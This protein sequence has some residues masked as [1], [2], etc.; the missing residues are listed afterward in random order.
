MAVS[1]KQFYQELYEEHLEE[2]AF[3]YDSLP[4]WREDPEGSWAD[5][6]EL[7]QRLETHI[8]ALVIGGSDAKRLLRKIVA[9]A[10]PGE[11]FVI[12]SVLCRHY[13]LADVTKIWE[14]LIGSPKDLKELATEDEEEADAELQDKCRAVALAVR[15]EYP[16]DALAKLTKLLNTPHGPLLPLVAPAV[17]PGYID[18]KA[19]HNLLK[20]TPAWFLADALRV[21]GDSG[22]KTLIPLLEPY[23][24]PQFDAQDLAHDARREAA[25][26]LLKL[27]AFD[28]IPTL[29]S[30]PALFAIPLALTGDNNAVA[31]LMELGSTEDPSDDVLYALGFSGQL[32]AVKP[33]V[34]AMSNEDKASLAAD[35]AQL[36]LA[37]D[38]V[39]EQFIDEQFA[40]EDLFEHE[41]EAFKNGE[42]PKHPSGAAYGEN[43]VKIS[44]DPEKW[45]AWLRVNRE[46]FDT[47]LC[48]RLGEPLSPV[49]ICR[50]L[51][52]PGVPFGIRRYVQD[53]LAIRFKI[54]QAFSVYDPVHV[55]MAN[56]QATADAIKQAQA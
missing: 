11:L 1:L 53:E 47:N 34:L 37:T 15:F 30:E 42:M 51:Y 33:L 41:L 23:I 12:T 48:Y 32:A 46:R 13:A 31:K 38:L 4:T 8:D 54:R 6:A 14:S 3:L 26:A 39:E 44:C 40:E 27:G 29:L 19:A 17:E 49:S 52:K 7:E 16:Q 28:I 22:Q 55:Q 35:A 36:I 21:L 20:L 18:E 9:E 5:C 2:G 50:S 10:E 45:R 43:V 56:I 25:L 24:Q